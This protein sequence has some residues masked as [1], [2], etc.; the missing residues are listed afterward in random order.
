M[1][2]IALLD[3][4]RGYACIWILFHHLIEMLQ[5]EV[6]P[7]WEIVLNPLSPL[8]LFFTLSGFVMALLIDSKKEPYAQ[9]IFRR[10][11]R[12][13]PA[14]LIICLL[15]FAAF[16]II[17]TVLDALLPERVPVFASAYEHWPSQLLSKLSLLYGLLP[18][19]PHAKSAFVPPAWSVSVEWQFYLI[20]PLLA[21]CFSKGW[22][23]RCFFVFLTL[24]LAQLFLKVSVVFVG[25]Y[26]FYIV[27]GMLTY[28]LI[29]PYQT[30]SHNKR[31]AVF[32]M[33]VLLGIQLVIL[34][35]TV[36][37]YQLIALMLPFILWG[38]LMLLMMAN[39][40]PFLIRM[41]ERLFENQWIL[42]IG[43][44]SYSFYLL[45][46]LAMYA[47]LYLL[48]PYRVTMDVPTFFVAAFL[49]TLGLNMLIA[50]LSFN[51]IEVPT[52]RFASSWGHRLVDKK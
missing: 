30:A 34:A 15:Y 10:Y 25:K 1:K 21:V 41:R 50:K 29:D 26:L 16:P 7:V 40:Q 12:L 27:V 11:F 24:T 49:L 14:L 13:A 22:L 23:L 48:L 52:M 43:K 32:S 17:L 38:M 47:V 6:S 5:V 45:H 20:A 28:Y 37:V 9:Y 44:T 33:V 51:L 19:I 35:L 36:N 2:N 8:L 42:G 46:M 18:W 3:G 39:T 4:L 31:Y